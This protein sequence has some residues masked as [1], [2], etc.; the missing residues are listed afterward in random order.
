M[1]RRSRREKGQSTSNPLNNV[2]IIYSFIFIVVVK[3][4]LFS[5]LFLSSTATTTTTLTS[6]TTKKHIAILFSHLRIEMIKKKNSMSSMC[7]YSNNE[8]KENDRQFFRLNFYRELFMLIQPVLVYSRDET[9]S[10]GK[11]VF[12][13]FDLKLTK[14]TALSLSF[15]FWNVNFQVLRLTKAMVMFERCIA[16]RSPCNNVVSNAKKW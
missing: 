9:N 15:S 5:F 16:Q 14:R 1:S 6:T 7:S 3:T 2:C 8:Q 11:R 13:V 10:I 4:H 12:F